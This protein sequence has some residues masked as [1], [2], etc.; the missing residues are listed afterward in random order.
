MHRQQR[1]TPGEVGVGVPRGHGSGRFGGA[2]EEDR[3]HRV[4]TVVQQRLAYLDVL[5]VEAHR[6]GRGPQLPD[7]IE[8]FA[9][10]GVALGL[11]QEIAVGLLLVRFAAGHHVQQQPSA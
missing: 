8:E 7:D 6:F 11:V 4:G 9:G 5:T 2:A 10:A 3:R 1:L